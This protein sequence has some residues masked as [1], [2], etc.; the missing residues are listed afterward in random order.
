[1]KAKDQST[2]KPP[3]LLHWKLGLPLPYPTSLSL[4]TI[5]PPLPLLPI[6]LPPHLRHLPRPLWRTKHHPKPHN[7]LNNLFNHSILMDRD[8]VLGVVCPRESVGFG[9]EGG[10]EGDGEEGVVR[11]EGAEGSESV[12]ENEE[13]RGEGLQG[14]AERP[15]TLIGKQ[16]R[17]KREAGRKR[18][19]MQ[20]RRSSTSRGN[21]ALNLFMSKVRI[22]I[23]Q[24][25]SAA[26]LRQ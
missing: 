19:L 7:M 26:C 2:K 3:S 5:K 21:D 14:V 16:E 4:E 15:S 6:P 13:K 25:G 20:R 17:G 1:M 24:A 10:G 9:D 23:E 8:V 22:S 11:G 12:G 18:T